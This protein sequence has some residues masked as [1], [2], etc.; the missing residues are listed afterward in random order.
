M[1]YFD[2]FDDKPRCECGVFGILGHPRAVEFTYLGL[3]ALQHRGQESAGIVAADD[4]SFTYHHGMGLVATIFDSDSLSKL[5]GNLALG[6]NRYSTTGQS[7]LQNA[8]PLVRGI[9][10]GYPC[11][12]TQWE[13]C[14]RPAYPQ[15][16]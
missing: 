14:E 10:A 16:P 3:R 8:Q 6:H 7:T 5:E 9:Q 2:E 11:D 4:D 1:E 15:R 12:C 13:S